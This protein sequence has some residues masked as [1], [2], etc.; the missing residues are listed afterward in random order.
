M[1]RVTMRQ[2]EGFVAVADAGNF[3]R[4][5]RQL[6]L[7]QPALSLLVK[8]LETELG[9]SL[10][11]RTTRRVELTEAGRDFLASA[12]S[13]VGQLQ[14]AIDNA[15][16]FAQ[17]RRGRIRVAAPPLLA[18]AI[19]PSAIAAFRED[20][21]GISVELLDVMTDKILDAVRSGHAECGLGTF[22]AL[23]EEIVRTPL[24][25]DQLMLFGED[26][27]LMGKKSIRWSDLNGL[28]LVSLTRES[29]IRVLVEV[30][31]EAAEIPLKPAYEISQITTALALVDAGL[32][33]SVL[34]TY[35]LAATRGAKIRTRALVD[36]EISREVAMIHA[37][38][39]SPSPAVL[40]FLATMRRLTTKRATFWSSER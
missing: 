35:A 16:D 37:S 23:E 34:P 31:F 33:V 28:P 15:R 18:S 3:S 7:A 12:N 19:L 38:A 26:P 1:L 5:G 4:A 9:V 39:R 32:G 2:I 29:G 21:P 8:E 6:A 13:I 30:G 40:A 10:F 36:P 22:S 24:V 20:Y 11:D 25:R 17:R 27:A 14:D